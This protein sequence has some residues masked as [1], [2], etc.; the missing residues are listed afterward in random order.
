MIWNKSERRVEVLGDSCDCVSSLKP[1]GTI[2]WW[3]WRGCRAL[4]MRRDAGNSD[5]CSF[6]SLIYNSPCSDKRVD[7]FILFIL[8]YIWV[9]TWI[10]FHIFVRKCPVLNAKNRPACLVYSIT[11][12]IHFTILNISWKKERNV[13]SCWLP[14]ALIVF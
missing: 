7:A 3:C 5:S 8:F 10:V 4:M 13:I 1:L 11:I 12:C 9:V 14:S 6:C 2:L